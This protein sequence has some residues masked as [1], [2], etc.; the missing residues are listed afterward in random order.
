[1]ATRTIRTTIDWTRAHCPLLG[2]ERTS[3]GGA[4]MSA[5]DPKRTTSRRSGNTDYA[6][7]PSEQQR[8]CE[9]RYQAR[10]FLNLQDC[11]VL[12]SS[13]SW[14]GGQCGLKGS[15]MTEFAKRRIT[16]D[17]VILTVGV[18]IL[19]VLAFLGAL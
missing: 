3:L 16:G 4:A 15:A 10:A 17:V 5:N 18:A 6:V 12:H 19:T 13:R 1:M 8:M 14:S 9:G 11:E 7:S 2:V